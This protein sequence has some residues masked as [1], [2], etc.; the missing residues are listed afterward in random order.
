MSEQLFTDFVCV[1]STCDRGKDCMSAHQKSD[2][3]LWCRS[4]SFLL[5]MTTKRRKWKCG[6]VTKREANQREIYFPFLADVSQLRLLNYIPTF[7]FAPGA[8]SRCNE[9]VCE[10]NKF[11]NYGEIKTTTNSMSTD[12]AWC[13]FSEV[14]SRGFNVRFPLE[15]LKHPLEFS[16][17]LA[18]MFFNGFSFVSFI[19]FRFTISSLLKPHFY[20]EKVLFSCCA[21][22]KVINNSKLIFMLRRKLFLLFVKDVFKV[23]SSLSSAFAF[24]KRK[25][26]DKHS[27]SL[28]MLVRSNKSKSVSSTC[29]QIRFR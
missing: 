16:Q 29:Q 21:V 19:F 28:C 20:M 11:I 4:N 9:N 10:N 25:N 17:L 6:K 2:E 1:L 22:R 5:L 18:E 8:C 26:A 7:S 3:T 15:T 27:F 13:D 23:N 24:A 12:S 14:H